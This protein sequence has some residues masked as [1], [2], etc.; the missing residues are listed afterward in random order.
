MAKKKSVEEQISKMDMQIS[1]WENKIST[2][3]E[4]RKQL[5]K[6]KMEND[7]KQLYHTIQHKGLNLAQVFDVL[8]KIK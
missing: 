1:A 6:Q 3:K 5:V 4:E 7:M 2:M 8:D